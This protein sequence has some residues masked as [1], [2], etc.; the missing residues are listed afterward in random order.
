MH[1][2][3]NI[4]KEKRKLIDAST[5]GN[6]KKSCHSIKKA[7]MTAHHATFKDI[8][9]NEEIQRFREENERLTK[10]ESPTIIR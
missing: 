1:N 2:Y 10:L 9:Q 5:N 4:E 7:K 6:D 3:S 8:F